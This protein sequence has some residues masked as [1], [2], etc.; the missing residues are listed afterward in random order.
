M[1][2]LTA[3]EFADFDSALEQH[4]AWGNRFEEGR[5]R[6]VYGEALRREKRRKEAR[7]QLSA[8]KS[9]FATV[10]A[11]VWER[12]A[13]DELRAAGARIPRAASGAALTAQEERIAALVAEGLSN[14]EIAARLVLS[15]KTVEGHLRNA[16]EKLEVTSRTQLARALQR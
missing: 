4:W 5:T 1:R 8:A 12:R 13:R 16:F 10:G 15:T 14:K 2:A 6:L 3:G 9:A 7:E 11:K